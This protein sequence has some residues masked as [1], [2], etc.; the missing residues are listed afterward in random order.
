MS[1][2]N[3]W[4]HFTLVHQGHATPNYFLT[5]ELQQATHNDTSSLLPLYGG[6]ALKPILINLIDA[7]SKQFVKITYNNLLKTAVQT[8]TLSFSPLAALN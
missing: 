2:S 1:T 4:G 3:I 6:S 8:L 5:F 7:S